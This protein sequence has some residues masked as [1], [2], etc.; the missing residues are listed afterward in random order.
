[1]LSPGMSQ[2]QEKEVL[3]NIWYQEQEPFSAP[4][5]RRT[6]VL[7]VGACHNPMYHYAE[8][9]DIDLTAIDLH[10]AD[11]TVLR[12]DFLEVPILEGRGDRLKKL[13]GHVQS[14]PADHYHAVVLSLVLSYIPGPQERAEMIRRARKVLRGPTQTH[15]FVPDG[16]LIVVE[17]LSTDPQGRSSSLSKLPI[18]KKWREDIETHGFQFHLYRRLARSHAMVFRTKVITEAPTARGLS[19]AFDEEA[20]YHRQVGMH[21]GTTR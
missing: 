6:R 7:D 13:N 20:E 4:T 17:P 12:G 14:L 3:E 10:P 1:M 18:M 16:C 11:S 19:I 8:S 9:M 2:E 15:P 21:G 5:Q